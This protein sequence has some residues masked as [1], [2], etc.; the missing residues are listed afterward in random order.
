MATEYLGAVKIF[1]GNF[2]IKGYAFCAGQLLS[3][4]QNAALFS[5]LGTA[6]GGNGVTNF[7]LPD[8]RGRLPIGQGAGPGL[9]P[10]TMGEI[11]GSESVTILSNNVPSHTHTLNASATQGT[12]NVPGPS[13]VTG[14]L[15]AAPT[16]MGFYVHSTQTGYT[17][18]TMNVTALGLQGGN[19]PHNNIQPSM[20]IN[21]LIALQGIFPSRS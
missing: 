3:I 21:Y 18:E 19:L 17:A 12:T 4:Q 11:S 10:R 15:A 6:F 1:A 9:S 2:A 7:Q 5:L 14:T 8:L 13:L 20:G 16:D